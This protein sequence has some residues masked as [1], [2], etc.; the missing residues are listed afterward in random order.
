MST[1]ENNAKDTQGKKGWLKR[2]SEWI[3]A[4]PSKKIKNSCPS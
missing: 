4:E 2:L 3:T 1:K